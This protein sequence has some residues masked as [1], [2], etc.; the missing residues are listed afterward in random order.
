[1]ERTE[2]ADTQAKLDTVSISKIGMERIL[3]TPLGFGG[4]AYQSLI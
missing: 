1:M 4:R 2:L 3:S